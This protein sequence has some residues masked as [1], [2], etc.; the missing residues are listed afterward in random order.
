LIDTQTDGT[1][2]TT[3]GK[4]YYYEWLNG[5]TKKNYPQVYLF[6]KD[7]A[8][9]DKNILTIR[10]AKVDVSGFGLRAG[11]LIWI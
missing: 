2:T 4:I 5:A 3:A 9:T 11:I 10:N 6:T 7:E 8:K 1:S